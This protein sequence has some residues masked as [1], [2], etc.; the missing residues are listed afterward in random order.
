MHVLLLTLLLATGPAGAEDIELPIYV[1][2]SVCHECHGPGHQGGSC[3][4]PPN[5][6]HARAFEV[7]SKTVAAEIAALNGIPEEPQRSLICLGCHTTAAEEGPRWTAETFN[8]A[9]GVQCE[10]CHGAG[11][12]H[13]EA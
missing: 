10:A 9:D 2:Q 3:T 4:I 5:P 13:A 11:S 7:L 1:G 6:R 12:T 8:I